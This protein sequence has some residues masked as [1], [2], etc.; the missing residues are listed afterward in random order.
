MPRK[1][2]RALAAAVASL[3][4]A[5]PALAH[6]T[7]QPNEAVAGS[8][9]RFVVRV[10]NERDDAATTKIEVQLPESLVFVSFQPKAGWTRKAETRQRS[11]AVEVFGEQVTE[12]VATVTWEGGR[13]EP[14]EF[15][16]FGF[17]ARVPE[18]PSTLEFPAIQTYSSGEEVRWIG[19]ADAEEPAGRVTTYSLGAGEDAPGQLELLSR[20]AGGEAA[21]PAEA[22]DD[23]GDG[24]DGGTVLGVIGIALGALALVVSLV[25]RRTT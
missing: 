1:I 10:P 13:I 2:T 17:S 4:L 20:V 21:A 18:K 14:G 16:E 15:E 22:D 25:R 9:A 3:A 23:G 11:Q 19:P 24:T 12:Y 5:T 6:V 8:F 7:V